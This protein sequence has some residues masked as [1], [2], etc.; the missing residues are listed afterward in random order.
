MRKYLYTICLFFFLS[1]VY[2]QNP[3]EIPA[4]PTITPKDSLNQISPLSERA[5]FS[6][7]P[8]RSIRDLQAYIPASYKLYGQQ[9]F[10]YGLSN[11]GYSVALDGMRLKDAQHLPYFSIGQFSFQNTDASIAFGNAMTGFQN[12]RTVPIGDK[13]SIQYAEL[14]ALHKDLSDRASEISLQVPIWRNRK[15]GRSV[16]WLANVQY[17]TTTDQDPSNGTHRYADETTLQNILENPIGMSPIVSGFTPQTALTFSEVTPSGLEERKFRKNGGASTYSLYSR[18]EV[19]IGAKSMLSAGTL[20][21]DNEQD[22]YQYANALFNTA[23]NPVLEENGTDSYLKWEQQLPKIG[24]FEMKGSVQ[25]QYSNHS[26]IQQSRRH[27]DRFFEYDYIGRFSTEREAVYYQNFFEGVPVWE[28]AGYQDIKLDFSPAELNPSLAAYTDYI[29]NHPQANIT[30]DDEL[31]LANGLL[32]GFQSTSTVAPYNLWYSPGYESGI[33][34]KSQREQK[35]LYLQLEG[36]KENQSWQFGIEHQGYIFR[37]YQLNA[38]IL[39]QRMQMF[40]NELDFNN[41]ILIQ[42]GQSYDLNDPNHPAIMAGDSIFRNRIALVDKRTYFSRQI[43]RALGLSEEGTDYVDIQSLSPDILSLDLFQPDDL[44]L[45]D[46]NYYGYDYTGEKT[47]VKEYQDFF[48]EQNSEGIFSRLTPAFRPVYSAAYFNYGIQKEALSVQ[49][50]VRADRYDAN[51]PVL[52]DLDVIPVRNS[53]GVIVVEDYFEDYKPVLNVLPQVHIQWKTNKW[54]IGG[55]FVSRTVNPESINTFN[56]L[57]YLYFDYYVLNRSFTN[58]N[59]EPIRI[60]NTSFSATYQASSKWQL[61]ANLT[62]TQLLNPIVGSNRSEANPF[63]YAAIEN[64]E[65]T[66]ETRT[67]L[68]V[69]GDYHTQN[70]FG[71]LQAGFNYTYQFKPKVSEGFLPYISEFRTDF[72]SPLEWHVPHHFKGYAVYQTSSKRP[73]V[74]SNW[75]IGVFYQYRTGTQQPK[76]DANAFPAAQFGIRIRSTADSNDNWKLPSTHNLDLKI[77]KLFPL[78]KVNLA[79]YLWANNLLNTQNVLRVYSHT[80]KADEDGFVQSPEG[81]QLLS[82]VYS[83]QAFLNQYKFKLQN[84]AFYGAPRII[85]IGL[86]LEY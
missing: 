13:F 37:S 36:K 8:I 30:T 41:P 33:Y 10:Q 48:S 45:Y 86:R 17:Y 44:N 59:L 14:S 72:L 29:I 22:V 54:A 73:F 83:T 78:G 82:N 53:E 19:P 75:S 34:A 62:H 52:K 39:W 67:N 42:N 24:G 61:A 31:R 79:A 58:P 55:D 23:N 32:N 64:D 63:P 40:D 4:Q 69:S 5:I 38:K 66:P 74:F 85:R 28:L 50:G 51:Q 65:S 25:F 1:S 35:G 43:R 56:P 77:E 27:K 81:L 46:V 2:A 6:K 20:V 57:Q 16:K 3:I 68:I 7:L 71:T 12:I 70:P 11:L 84:P 21:K 26:S 60:N 18:L 76:H 47:D 80:G 15:T 9:S 49:L